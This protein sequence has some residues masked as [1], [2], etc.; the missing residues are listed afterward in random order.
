MTIQSKFKSTMRNTAG[1]RNAIERA[2]AGL[3]LLWEPRPESWSNPFFSS[4]RS[5]KV[6]DIYNKDNNTKNNNNKDNN[7]KDNNSKDD[8][9]KD[10][11][12]KT[13]I[14]PCTHFPEHPDANNHKSNDNKLSSKNLSPVLREWSHL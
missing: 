5:T 6:E 8:N 7:N 2:V 10:N 11:Y 12:R 14:L 4:S 1:Q 13:R 3:L 9:N